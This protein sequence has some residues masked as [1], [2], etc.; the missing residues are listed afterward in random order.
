MLK[1]EVIVMISYILSVLT[2]FGATSIIG[3]DTI[4]IVIDRG[5][6]NNVVNRLFSLGGK[7]IGGN[8][9]MQ[10]FLVCGVN[11]KVIFN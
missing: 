7:R 2:A 11:V 3:M 1:R 4:V 8:S 9:V 10:L 6:Y 5:V